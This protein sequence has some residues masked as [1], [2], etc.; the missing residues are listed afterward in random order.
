MIPQRIQALFEFI[1]FL[2][3]NKKEYI[4]KYIPV[5]NK[6]EKIKFEQKKLKSEKNYIDK[7][8]YEKLQ[9]EIDNDFPVIYSN[10]YLPIIH[11]LKELRIWSGD[12]TCSSIW[13]NNIQAIF[14]FKRNFEEEDVFKVLHFKNKYLRFRNETNSNFLSLQLVFNDLDKILKEL[15][16]F[17][18]DSKKNEFEKFESKIIGVNSLEQAIEGLKN[19]DKNLL[20]SIPIKVLLDNSDKQKIPASSINIKNDIIMGDKIEAKNISNNKGPI[21]IGKKNRIETYDND[22]DKKAFKWQKWGII[23]A[24]LLAII[25]IVLMIIIESKKV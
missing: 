7:Q 5:C 9:E 19:N 3:N 17:F 15:F 12:Q 14:D 1:D 16:D 18:K 13:N 24:T 21:S 2:D 10:V 20:Y 8:K 23:I 6:L 25:T 22:L 11:K 4:Q